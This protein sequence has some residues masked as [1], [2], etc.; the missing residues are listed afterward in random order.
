MNAFLNLRLAE[1]DFIPAGFQLRSNE[2]C[3]RSEGSVRVA[4]GH[5]KAKPHVI[6]GVEND[7]NQYDRD[8]PD[9]DQAVRFRAES[10]PPEIGKYS[11]SLHQGQDRKS[12]RSGKKQQ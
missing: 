1:I 3:D 8:E 5:M 9:C 10:S 12:D 11:I 6:P 4:A 2:V 7:W